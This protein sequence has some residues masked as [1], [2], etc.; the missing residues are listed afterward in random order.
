MP[1]ISITIFV[2]NQEIIYSLLGEVLHSLKEWLQLA[3]EKEKKIVFIL[4]GFDKL[5]C[6]S[7]DLCL[8]VFVRMIS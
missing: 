5:D 4:D 2:L 1:S 8:L 6:E 3:S 7:I